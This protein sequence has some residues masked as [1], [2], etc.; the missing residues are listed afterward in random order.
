MYA[1]QNCIMPWNHMHSSGLILLIVAICLGACAA[2]AS[3]PGQAVE[4]TAPA[5]DTPSPP[6]A[7]AAAATTSTATVAAAST[8]LPSTAEPPAFTLAEPGPYFP[9]KRSF[10]IPASESRTDRVIGITVWYPALKPV[11]YTGT[12]AQDAASDESGAPYPLLLT[13]TIFGNEFAAHLTSH[14][15]V[16]A[17][18][19]A[20]E[21]SQGFAA[22]V[23]GYP[24]EILSM[25][26]Y[27]AASPP[28]ELDGMLDA[29]HS[30]ALGYSFSGHNTLVLSGARV[31]PEQ[32]L[33]KCA[34]GPVL[35]P[36][37]SENITIEQTYRY[38]CEMATTWDDFTAQVGTEITAGEDGLWHALSDERIRAAMPMAPDGPWLFGER[39]LASIDLP[40][41]MICGTAD[42]RDT[43][44][45]D[46]CVY[47]FEHL[48]TAEKG[49]ISFVDQGH[50]M[51]FDSQ[52][53]A[54]IK[55]FITA[56]FGYHLQGKKEYRDAYSQEFVE[57]FGDLA[58]GAYTPP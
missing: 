26:D 7:A 2:S 20:Q 12:Q 27:L 43:A 48:G 6:P 56:F 34:Q 58:W 50:L 8:P 55:H 53:K 31:D 11:D 44:Y 51:V 47:A 19:D 54:R 28:D 14:G 15:F 49:L 16:V 29:D 39:G 9:G 10:T 33:A 21:P 35:G 38:F 52:P 41:L 13:S 1:S 42:S 5:A 46:S 57:Q 40:I 22:W 30:G 45:I 18:V 3:T 4:P 37:P 36:S 25:L 32:Y 23:I 17:G 24:L